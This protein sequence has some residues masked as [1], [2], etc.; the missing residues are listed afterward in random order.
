[1]GSWSQKKMKIE[2]GYRRKGKKYTV[3]A[4]EVIGSRPRTVC[5]IWKVSLNNSTRICTETQKR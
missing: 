5:Q 3:L 4:R 1:M 2:E